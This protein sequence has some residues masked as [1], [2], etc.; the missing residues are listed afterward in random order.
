MIRS[1]TGLYNASKYMIFIILTNHVVSAI[2]AFISAR[3]YNNNL[4]KKQSIWQ[5]INL[6]HTIVFTNHGIQSQFGFRIRF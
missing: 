2:D 6:D 1:S 3:A 4:L 5:N